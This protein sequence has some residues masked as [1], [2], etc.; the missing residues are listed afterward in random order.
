MSARLELLLE[1]R[2]GRVRLLSPDVGFFTEALSQGA[3][4]VAG[5]RA[6]SLLTLG[7][8]IELHV[9]AGAAGVITSSPPDRLRAPFG[10]GEVLYEL[11][12]SAAAKPKA[13]AAASR[14]GDLLL[15]SPQSG[16]FYHRP[17]PSD[18]PFVAAGATIEDGRPIGMIEVMKTFAHVPYR[19]AGSLPKRAKVLRL[20]AADGAD[21][22]QGDPLLEVEPG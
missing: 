2:D 3:E 21:V 9:P 4:V 5:E 15:R 22:K 11:A 13:P 20:I 19:A 18:P 7:R 10:F 6:G 14:G 12:A 17:S 1:G 8:S 16:R